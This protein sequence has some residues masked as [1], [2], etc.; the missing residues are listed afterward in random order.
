M[1]IHLPSSHCLRSYIRKD[2]KLKLCFLSKSCKCPHLEIYSQSKVLLFSTH[3]QLFPTSLFQFDQALKFRNCFRVR[4]QPVHFHN[5]IEERANSVSLSTPSSP[6]DTLIIHSTYVCPM[7]LTPSRVLLTSEKKKEVENLWHED[8]EVGRMLTKNEKNQ[9]EGKN[10]SRDEKELI[11]ILIKRK[12]IISWS[13]IW[14]FCFKYLE[15]V[16]ILI[17]SSESTFDHW[18]VSGNLSSRTCTRLVTNSRRSR[19]IEERRVR[20]AKIE[21]ILK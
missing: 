3:C 7:I 8:I 2:Q 10:Y 19:K 4:E 14:K 9:S 6:S 1:A 12:F 17:S 18:V 5:N 13:E 15:I 20:L 11:S 21:V 16:V